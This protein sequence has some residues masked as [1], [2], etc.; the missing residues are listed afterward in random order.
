VDA[1]LAVV[2]GCVDGARH[3]HE[4]LESLRRQTLEAGEVVVALPPSTDARG[5]QAATG[6]APPGARV[7]E[8]PAEAPGALWNAAIAA[9]AGPLIACVEEGERL[10]PRYVEATTAAL[11]ADAGLAFVAPWVAVDGPGLE[12][13]GGADLAAAL[14]GPH[15][16][17]ARPVVRR[18]AWHAVGGFDES[19]PALEDWDLGLRLLA[20]GFRGLVVEASLVERTPRLA[21]WRRRRLEDAVHGPAMR[22]VLERHAEAVAADVGRL[23]GESERRHRHLVARH[24]E[25]VER[26]RRALDELATLDRGLT[27]AR[28]AA[29]A[30][31][32]DAIDWGDLGRS[33]PV[34]RDW[35]YDRGTPVDRY[36]IE[37]F[38]AAHAADVRGVVLEVQE[39]DLTRRH[40]GERVERAD[41]VD[42]DPANGRATIIADL[43]AATGIASDTYDCFI[44]TQTLHVIDDMVA[45]LRE[46]RRILKPGGVLLAT[47]PCASR[48]CLEYG[49][50]GDFWRLTPAG[51]RRLFAEIF[52]PDAVEVRAWGNVLVTAAFL[53]GLGHEE[54]APAD[55]ETVD[56]YFPLLVGVRAVKPGPAR[57]PAATRSHPVEAPA[58]AILLY[59]R[60]AH[61]APD[62]HGLCVT[63]A[64]FRAQ[65]EHL[66]RELTP[67]SLADLVA[68]LAAGALPP[69]AVAVTFDDGYVDNLTAASPI[70]VEQGVPA[71]FFVTAGEL[72][73]AHEFWWDTLEQIFLAGRPVPPTLEVELGG[74]PRRLATRTAAERTTAHRAVYEALV[75]A[76]PEAR[77]DLAARLVRWSGLMLVTRPDH[78]P[79]TGEEVRRLGRRPGH[80]IGAHGARHLALPAQA[81]EV[82]QRE[83]V[84]GKARLEALLGRPVTLFAYP[85]G[86]VS[87]EAVAA[88]GAA[89]FAGAATCEPA[90]VRPG[91]D[92]L[93]LPRLPVEAAGA[94]ELF[95]TLGTRLDRA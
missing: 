22:A 80:A 73:G 18:T 87:G 53:H 43:R 14:L 6:L 21:S 91:C 58:A 79:M 32:G 92:P 30:V 56:P 61:A 45:V 42:I 86:A 69:R 29:R 71:T 39:P 41:V 52:P 55:L 74:G 34:S 46:A 40:G 1:H 75:A 94:E 17:P 89:G 5:R 85:F 31:A 62:T 10:A 51:A 11:D 4:T 47:L 95:R 82:R 70:L 2:V 66:R 63:P 7:V 20:A 24:R 77:D 28:A 72:D 26:R 3:L 25:L 81:A 93:R 9:A 48:V 37:R 84:D 15:A 13:P 35:G 50:D 36:Y 67:L 88:A 57:P 68:A 60:V 76:A 54:L 33:A 65:M 44:L 23:L 64:A 38:V 90:L 83:V 12:V 59:H 19:L 8:A 27:Q 49:R 16:W 78:R